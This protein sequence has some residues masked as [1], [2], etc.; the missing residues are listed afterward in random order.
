MSASHRILR[1]LAIAACALALGACS[2]ILPKDE[3]M[4]ILQPQVQVTPDPSWPHV[5]WQLAVTR[6]STNDMLD[7]RRMVV[8]PTPGRVEVYKGVAWNDTVPE[9]V[10]TAAI[11]AFEDSGKI[12]AVGR[13][14]NGLHT[15]F[16]LQFDLRDYQAVYHT[17]A[18]P[19]EI[20]LVVSAKL[21]DFAGSRAVASRTFRATATASSTEVHA[22]A[23]AFDTALGSLLHDVVGWTLVNGQQARADDAARRRAAQH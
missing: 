19:P 22:V 13:Q 9:V 7:S 8:N 4:E 5:D 16:A 17:P 11:A 6:P 3:P 15:D 10:Q 21:V 12:N 23:R 2:A 1:N 20:T 14:A 18:G